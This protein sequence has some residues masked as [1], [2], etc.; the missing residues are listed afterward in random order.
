MLTLGPAVEGDGGVSD[1][2]VQDLDP[3]GVVGQVLVVLGR[4]LSHLQTIH[5]QFMAQL[6]LDTD[7]QSHSEASN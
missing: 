4:Y 5:A 1:E 7:V 2:V 6:R 3:G